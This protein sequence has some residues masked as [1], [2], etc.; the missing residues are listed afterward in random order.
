M[1]RRHLLLLL[2]GV[3]TGLIIALLS[4][5]IVASAPPRIT[6]TPSVTP[7]PPATRVTYTVQRGDT[8]FAIGRR[9]GVRVSDIARANNILNPSLIYVGQVLIIPTGGS[10]P[11]GPP[12]TPTPAPGNTIRYTVQ[13][14][15]TLYR[16]A[17]R[18]GATVAA[19]RAANNLANV[20]LIYV[21]QVLIIPA[22][23]GVPTPA[24]T[25][26]AGPTATLPPRPT[27]TV[28]DIP[29]AFEPFEKGFMIWLGD[30]KRIWVAVCCT[31]TQPLGGRWLSYDDAF[32]EGLPESDPALTPPPGLYQPVRG[33]GLVWRTLFD[34]SSGADLRSLLG[35]ATAPEQAYT[36]HVE[37]QP[38]G[39]YD[40]SGGWNGRPGAWTINT[41]DGK[42][43]YF[44][45]AGPAWSLIQ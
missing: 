35:W 21:G 24:P 3:L 39:F 32:T 13:R 34:T 40:P 20:N 27:P 37:Y 18:F 10:A 1:K 12:P 33:F 19:I 41:P 5:S 4:H 14:G 9:F 23:P 42:R 30:R 6:T 31:S 16:I 28:R 8:L 11:P 15:D 22:G 26:P 36:A 45:E 17:L 25:Q 44:H 38:G 7:T 2:L 29:A 43:Y